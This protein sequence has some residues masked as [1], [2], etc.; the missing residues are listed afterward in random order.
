ML[1]ASRNGNPSQ[2]RRGNKLTLSSEKP[3]RGDDGHA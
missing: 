1:F 3:K 2:S